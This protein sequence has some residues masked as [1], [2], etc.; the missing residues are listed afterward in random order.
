MIATKLHGGTPGTVEAKAI[1]C[2]ATEVV[3]GETLANGLAA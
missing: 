1:S 3:L 2:L